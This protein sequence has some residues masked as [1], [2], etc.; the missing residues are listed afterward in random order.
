MIEETYLVSNFSVTDL[1]QYK[2]HEVKLSC[3]VKVFYTKIVMKA[4]FVSF[5]NKSIKLWLQ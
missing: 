1:S 4:N 3:F 2:I 5:D